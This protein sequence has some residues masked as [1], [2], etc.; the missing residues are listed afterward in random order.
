MMIL[1]GLKWGSYAAGGVLLAGGLLF[2]TDGMSYLRSSAKSVQTAVKDGV[3]LEF[4]LQ[5]ARDMVEDILPELRANVRVI[6]Q[7]EV[8]IAHLRNEIATAGDKLAV[9]RQTVVALR[10]QLR[11]NDLTFVSHGRKV[12]RDSLTEQL[13]SGLD[14][15]K[16]SEATLVSKQRLLEAREKSLTAAQQVLER[17][18][19]RKSELEQKIEALTAQ[20]RLVQA[21]SVGTKVSIDD[22]Q[23]ARADKL[24]TDI[25]K[26]LDTAQRVLAH[27]SELIEMDSAI[28]RLDISEADLLSEVDNLL[29]D[30][31]ELEG[32]HS[33]YPEHLASDNNAFREQLD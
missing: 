6:A 27:E 10:E 3:P 28:V 15:Y 2:G 9:Q 19:A 16:Q 25:Q 31:T 20:Y 1:K 14:R 30:D 13:A 21:Q 12:S 29:E 32:A 5:R 23:L 22:S 18:R 8:E 24:I 17:S 26:R 4:E 33:M 7:E 11:T